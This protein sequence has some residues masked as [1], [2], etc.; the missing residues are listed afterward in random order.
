MVGEHVL[1]QH[2]LLPGPAR[3]EDG[4]AMGSH[5]IDIREVQRTW[6]IAYEHPDPHPCGL[7]AHLASAADA[8]VQ[9]V[10]V[11]RLRELLTAQGDA[12]PVVGLRQV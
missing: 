7:A 11:G 9:H 10:P 8:A 12:Q 3:C 4:I 1:T 2:D 5:H 6:A